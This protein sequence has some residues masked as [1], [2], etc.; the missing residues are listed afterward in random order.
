MNNIPQLRFL[1]PSDD[2]REYILS[3]HELHGGNQMIMRF[4]NGYGAS[5]VQHSGSYG[6]ENNLAELAV[7]KFYGPGDLDW[8]LCYETEVTNDVIGHLTKEECIEL[9]GRIKNL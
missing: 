8:H 2:Y 1:P 6:H 3:S 5:V 7:I 9:F 4:P